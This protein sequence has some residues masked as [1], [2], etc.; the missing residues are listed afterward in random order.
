[1]DDEEKADI[2]QKELVEK[3]GIMGCCMNP[4][5]PFDIII[6]ES[7]EYVKILEEYDVKILTDREKS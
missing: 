7:E 2:R 1:M 4:Y 5:E 6:V 3:Y